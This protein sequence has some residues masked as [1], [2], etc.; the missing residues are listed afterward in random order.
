MTKI[1]IFALNL[2]MA[3]DSAYNHSKFSNMEE[4]KPKRISTEDI[5][6]FIDGHD[7]QRKI[8]NLLYR[9]RDD[10]I[11]VVYRD[12]NDIKRQKRE[13]LPILLGQAFRVQKIMRR[14]Q[15]GIDQTYEPIQNRCKKAVPD[16]R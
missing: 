2:T 4:A 3:V 11:T 13:F 10:F 15:T 1:C 9:Y 6:K 5:E 7:P 14:R 16:K 12:E 8:V